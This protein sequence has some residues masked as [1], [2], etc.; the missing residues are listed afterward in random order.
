MPLRGLRV[1][2]GMVD[3]K[4]V[5]GHLSW[6]LVVLALTMQQ[7]KARRGFGGP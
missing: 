7:G 1:R 4:R 6:R 2:E 3:Q 5:L